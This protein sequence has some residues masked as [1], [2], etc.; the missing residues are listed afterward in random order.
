M[1]CNAPGL[2]APILFDQAKQLERHHYVLAHYAAPEP[3]D[4]RVRKM[5]PKLNV[6]ATVP[7]LKAG[8][9]LG[10]ICISSRLRR[11][12]VALVLGGSF[13]K[14]LHKLIDRCLPLTL[15]FLVPSWGVNSVILVVAHF[16]GSWFSAV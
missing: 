8:A 13:I 11:R 16:V 12:A 7:G 15:L 5:E 2:A 3:F 4:G 10:T 6:P 1:H 9:V 14:H